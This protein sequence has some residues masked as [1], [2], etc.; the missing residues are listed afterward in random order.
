[1]NKPRQCKECGGTFLYTKKDLCLSCSQRNELEFQ[2]I[3]E[4]LKQRPRTSIG[5]VSTTLDISVAN[6]Q[7]FIDQGRIE[8]IEK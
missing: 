1:M 2:K 7:K 4:F 5:V 6:I 8:M 3:K